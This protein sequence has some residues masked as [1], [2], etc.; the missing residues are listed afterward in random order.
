[1]YRMFSCT[2]CERFVTAQLLLLQ[3]TLDKAN[4]K[5]NLWFQIFPGRYPFAYNEKLILTF[6]SLKHFKGV[7]TI[8]TEF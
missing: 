8:R 2:Y 1:M 6:V 3:L 4:A 7:H 5:T